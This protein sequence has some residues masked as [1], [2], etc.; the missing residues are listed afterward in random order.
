MRARIGIAVCV[1]CIM[2]AIAHGGSAD[3]AKKRF[4]AGQTAYDLGRFEQAL[5]SFSSAY[6]LQARPAI[7]YNIA[8]CHRQ[9]N[10]YKE[11][12]FFYRRY[13][14]LAPRAA[15]ANQVQEFIKEMEAKAVELPP[16]F[17]PPPSATDVPAVAAPLPGP[18][19]PA[20][21]PVD[22]HAA[23][24]PAPDNASVTQPAAVPAAKAPIYG[25][26]WFWTVV[27][28]VVVA[29]GASIAYVVSRPPS[30][31]LGQVGP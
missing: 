17:E 3:E 25:R 29:A 18:P 11:A 4:L 15:N 20:P 30:P 31:T 22:L 13:L 27:G 26:W 5:K 14:T 16:T 19:P 6:E 2:P 23:V 12:A 21:S 8:Q 24:V 9:M 10:H 7:L 1:L 28:V